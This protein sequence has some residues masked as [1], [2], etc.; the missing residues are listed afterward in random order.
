MEVEMEPTRLAAPT[1][2]ERTEIRLAMAPMVAPGKTDLQ[3][4]VADPKAAQRETVARAAVLA[5]RWV[6]VKAGKSR[7][8]PIKGVAR[9][10]SQ[11]SKV[12]NRGSPASRAGKAASK[13]ANR[14]QVVPRDPREVPPVDLRCL[15][16]AVV[17]GAIP[18][19]LSEPCC[20]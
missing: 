2:K 20:A 16:A 14:V 7:W 3:R 19:N 5:V 18:C 10:A 17:A 13:V 1:E 4:A 6:R 9:E 12:V 8:H 15:A 11:G